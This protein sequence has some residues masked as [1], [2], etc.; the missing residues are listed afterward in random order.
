MHG[1]NEAKKKIQ[2]EIRKR[3]S[4]F[5][6]L[7][8]AGLGLFVPIALF[9][10]VITVFFYLYESYI[11]TDVSNT[12]T[13]FKDDTMVGYLKDMFEVHEYDTSLSPSS[14]GY[15]YTNETA[16][17]NNFSQELKRQYT[18]WIDEYK[19]FNIK[20][21]GNTNY[22]YKTNG[23]NI[24]LGRYVSLI[25]YQSY[26]N[27]DSFKTNYDDEYDNL[28]VHDDVE[29]REYEGERVANNRDVR[30]FYEKAED[31]IG[32]VFFLFPGLR[33]IMG[34]SISADISISKVH[35]KYVT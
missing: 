34:N 26:L 2:E 3:K 31:K 4:K 24:D 29:L 14:T 18:I 10:F 12:N 19:Q 28:V 20:P 9:L 35:P 16:E 6:A 5:I 25:N 8:G 27:L 23:Y 15:S 30:N 17:D 21:K 22:N 13:I 11:V 7:G 32:S 33:E 1:N